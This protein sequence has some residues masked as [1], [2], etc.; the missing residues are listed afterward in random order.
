MASAN[1]QAQLAALLN[2]VKQVRRTHNTLSLCASTHCACLP[3]QLDPDSEQFTHLR[4]QQEQL[5]EQQ[6][7]RQHRIAQLQQQQAQQ[8]QGGRAY[9]STSAAHPSAAQAQE[10]RARAQLERDREEI[11]RFR[12]NRQAS[13]PAMQRSATAPP[14]AESKTNQKPP[15]KLNQMLGTFLSGLDVRAKTWEAKSDELVELERAREALVRKQNKDIEDLKK[16]DALARDIKAKG[17]KDADL[18]ALLQASI[19]SKTSAEELKKRLELL[20]A[21]KSLE[22]AKKDELTLAEQEKLARIEYEHMR[23]TVLKLVGAD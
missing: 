7:L 3:L 11:M 8:Q 20:R 17:G 21:G 1:P 6:R 18:V 4:Q 2:Q 5:R 12:R 16:L 13:T 22:D 10:A 15:S 14:S 9:A 23:L 19:D